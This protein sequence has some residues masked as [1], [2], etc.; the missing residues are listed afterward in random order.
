MGDLQAFMKYPLA[1]EPRS[2]WFYID[3]PK[4]GWSH[5]ADIRGWGFLTGGGS[6]ALGLDYEEAKA[7]QNAIAEEIVQIWNE[8]LDPE[9]QARFTK[10]GESE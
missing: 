7:I 6:G 2:G 4:K 3:H 8:R 1:Y 10:D 5:I 9:A